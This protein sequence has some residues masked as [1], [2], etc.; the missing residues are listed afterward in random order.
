M[1]KTFWGILVLMFLALPALAQQVPPSAPPPT[2]SG[3]GHDVKVPAAKVPAKAPTKAQATT[4]PPKTR[5]VRPLASPQRTCT[6]CD[7]GDTCVIY[8]GEGGAVRQANGVMEYTNRCL[9]DGPL[10]RH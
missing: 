3:G 1:N 2:S 6:K 4:A 8:H 5:V 10:H 7:A 9:P